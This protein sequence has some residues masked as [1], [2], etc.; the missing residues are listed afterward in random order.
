MYAPVRNLE[1][2]VVHAPV[3]TSSANTSPS[4]TPPSTLS[5]SPTVARGWINYSSGSPPPRSQMLSPDSS[6]NESLPSTARRE[7]RS[8]LRSSTSPYDM[9]NQQKAYFPR[10]NKPRDSPSKTFIENPEDYFYAEVLDD[11]TINSMPIL[12]LEKVKIRSFTF[13][14]ATRNPEDLHRFSSSSDVRTAVRRLLAR[15]RSLDIRRSVVLW[16]GHLWR[17]I[18]AIYRMEAYDTAINIIGSTWARYSRLAGSV[19]A[20]EFSHSHVPV[21]TLFAD[22]SIYSIAHAHCES[23]LERL[24]LIDTP[25]RLTHLGGPKTVGFDVEFM[26]GG[27]ELLS[28]EV[29]MD[30]VIKWE[31]DG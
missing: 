25:N 15:R 14:P 11:I 18:G 12:L 19:L 6:S 1:L 8:I 2:S 20:D 22:N 3:S 21:K 4:T 17:E 7:K 16:R 31:E 26:R 29:S 9:K 24:M 23:G 13:R 28:E 27:E 10:N 5:P 30:D